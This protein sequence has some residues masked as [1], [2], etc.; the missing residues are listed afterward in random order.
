ML[1]QELTAGKPWIPVFTGMTLNDRVTPMSFPRRRES[2]FNNM[3]SEY[4]N[5]GVIPSRN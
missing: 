4:P 1:S 3:S 2:I 5:S